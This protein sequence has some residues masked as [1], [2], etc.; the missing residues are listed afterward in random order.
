MN[1]LCKQGA[2]NVSGCMHVDKC[3]TNGC[4][5]LGCE[6]MCSISMN[7]YSCGVRVFLCGE[8]HEWMSRYTC[9]MSRVCVFGHT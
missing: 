6:F 9:N 8:W 5:Y 1:E 4:M 7:E 3:G 2:C